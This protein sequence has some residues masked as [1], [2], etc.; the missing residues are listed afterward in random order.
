EPPPPDHLRR[1]RP[2]G[3]VLLLAR[4]AGLRAP[5]PTRGRPARGRR[6]A[7]RVGRLPGADRRAGGAAQHPISGRGPGR[8]GATAVLPAGARGQGRQEPRPPRRPRGTRTAGRAADGSA[9]G[10]VRPARGAG[11]G[12]R[13]ALRARAPDECRPHRADRPRGQRVLPGL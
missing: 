6:S 4:R 12:T 8:A 3:A 10:R 9:G 1:P 11:S 7:G 13:P 5:R 2:T